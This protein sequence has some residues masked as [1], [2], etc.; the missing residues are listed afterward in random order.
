MEKPDSASPSPTAPLSHL[1]GC[2]WHIYG[3]GSLRPNKVMDFSS[4]VLCGRGKTTPGKKP[5]V[6]ISTRCGPSMERV[7]REEKSSYEYHPQGESQ[8]PDSS[9]HGIKDD[10][11]GRVQV[12]VQ[13]RGL[14]LRLKPI[15]RRLEV[16]HWGTEGAELS[17]LPV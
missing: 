11:S 2:G 9:G 12:I 3:S 16:H 17:C 8:G 5:E 4:P 6:E 15:H 10:L 1:L 14:R 13:V 7:R